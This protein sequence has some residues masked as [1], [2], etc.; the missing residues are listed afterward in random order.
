MENQHYLA[1]LISCSRNQGRALLET[2]DKDQVLMV[3]Q[4][5]FNLTKNRPVL[6]SK[7]KTLLKKHTKFIS[8]LLNKK[9]TDKKNYS[10]IRS[11]SSKIFDLIYSARNTLSKAIQ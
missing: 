6:S 10:L 11:N 5:V 8:Q 1:L 2:A 9:N 3:V 4:T 7:C